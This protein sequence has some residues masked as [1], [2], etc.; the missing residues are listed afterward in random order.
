[1]SYRDH[2]RSDAATLE[3]GDAL[4]ASPRVL[5]G[6]ATF[7]A[8]T[9][10]ALGIRSVFDLATA[11]LFG[12][13]DLIALVDSPPFDNSAVDGFGRRLEDLAAQELPL[14]GEIR[15]GPLELISALHVCP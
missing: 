10:A 4:R 15:A 3:I 14:A 13:A 1:M 6:V 12:A 8:D 2:L 11:S 9:L 7:A 5:L